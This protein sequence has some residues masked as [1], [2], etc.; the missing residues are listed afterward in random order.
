MALQ[1]ARLLCRRNRQTAQVGNCLLIR[2]LQG[3]ACARW[4]EIEECRVPVALQTCIQIVVLRRT[5][6]NTKA[7]ADNRLAMKHAGCPGKADA[8]IE[9]PVVRVVQSWIFWAR[10]RVDWGGIW[11]VLGTRSKADS[12]ERVDVE[13]CGVIIGFVSYAVLSP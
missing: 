11:P 10:C 13:N 5:V 4:V 3:R 8:R 9:V 1:G 7:R 12:M 6:V 2:R